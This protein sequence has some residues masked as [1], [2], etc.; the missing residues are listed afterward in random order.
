MPIAKHNCGRRQLQLFFLFVCLLPRLRNNY[1]Q[2]NFQN[3]SDSEQC[4]ERWIL[5]FLFNVADGLPRH[6]RSLRQHVQGKA[7]LF[8]FLF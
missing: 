1:F 2:V 5:H 6:A 7:T 4:V 3:R 8:T